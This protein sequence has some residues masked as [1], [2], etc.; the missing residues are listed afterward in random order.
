MNEL[1]IIR[2]PAPGLDPDGP[3]SEIGGVKI[4][5]RGVQWKQGVVVYIILYVVLLYNT[6]PIHCTPLRLHPPF[7]EY[8]RCQNPGVRNH[9]FAKRSYDMKIRTAQDKHKTEKDEKWK[10][11]GSSCSYVQII[12]SH[13]KKEDCVVHRCHFFTPR[14]KLWDKPLPSADIC[15]QNSIPITTQNIFGMSTPMQRKMKENTR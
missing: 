2:P 4:H 8:P 5:Q 9:G 3:G 11:C 10:T 14:N 15:S 12:N 6:T 1:L 13:C 7:D